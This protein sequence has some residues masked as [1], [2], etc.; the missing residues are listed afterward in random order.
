L[1]QKFQ[2]QKDQNKVTLSVC[3]LL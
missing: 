1:H 3:S 2:I